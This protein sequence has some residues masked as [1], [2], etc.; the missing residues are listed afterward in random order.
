MYE[1]IRIADLFINKR[2]EIV[3]VKSRNH[4]DIVYKAKM[5]PLVPER[6]PM[7]I[8]IDKNSASASEVIAGAL[9]QREVAITVGIKSF[10]K[11]SVQSIIDINDGSAVKITTARY[12]PAGDLKVDGVGIEPTIKVEPILEP[13][14]ILTEDDENERF[15]NYYLMRTSADPK[16][17]RQLKAAVNWINTR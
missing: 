1:S 16:K 5:K 15:L 3:T 11:G 4:G 12:Y 14:I 9:M 8:L 10:G 6:T 13:I 17:D 7:V 2:K